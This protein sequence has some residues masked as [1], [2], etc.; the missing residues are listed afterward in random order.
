MN[1]ELYNKLIVALGFFKEENRFTSEINEITEIVDGAKEEFFQKASKKASDFA[2]TSL[3]PMIIGAIA[4]IV[5]VSAINGGDFPKLAI[6]ALLFVG[7]IAACIPLLKK[8]GQYSNESKVKEM[9]E[10]YIDVEHASVVRHL[11]E[12]CVAREKFRK[13]FGEFVEFVPAQYRNLQAVSYFLTMVHDER[14]DSMKEAMRMYDEQVHRWKMESAAARTAQAKEF[15]AAAM[16][17]LNSQQAQS[18]QYLRQIRDAEYIR[19]LND[20]MK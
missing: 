13:E 12:L 15:E 6:C 19:L 18:N 7:A 16:M 20:V 9:W 10:H 4:G 17:A 14:A 2:A 5:G 8:Y 11:G 3:I 1:Q